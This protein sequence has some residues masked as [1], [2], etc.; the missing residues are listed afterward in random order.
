MSQIQE[1]LNATIAAAVNAQVTARVAEALAGD[2]FIG[3]MVQAA[4]TREVEVKVGGS[5]G[6]TVKT[7]FLNEAVRKSIED[8]VRAGVQEAIDDEKDAIQAE[9]RKAV[10]RNLTVIA[11][12]LAEQVVN[13]AD[14]PYGIKV[15]MQYPSRD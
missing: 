5:Y 7:T 8:V 6:R 11:D 15:E 13:A 2:Q 3:K 14:K 10:K 4:L 9:V 12:R 1:D